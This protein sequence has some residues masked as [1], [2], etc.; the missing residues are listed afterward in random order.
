L[1]KTDLLPVDR[2]SLKEVFP[3]AALIRLMKITK[4]P[5]YKVTKTKRYWPNCPIETKITLLLDTWDSIFQALMGQLSEICLEVPERVDVCSLASL[6]AHEDMPDAI[7]S[8]WVGTLFVDQAVQPFGD[9]YAAIW[10][11]K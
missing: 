3:F 11:P 8:A 5:P 4:R 1:N 9:N 10:I 7:M 6:K 2:S